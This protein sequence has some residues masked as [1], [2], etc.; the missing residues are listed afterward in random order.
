MIADIRYRATSHILFPLLVCI[1]YWI[2][3]WTILSLTLKHPVRTM[4]GSPLQRR[5]ILI[6]LVRMDVISQEALAGKSFKKHM[7]TK[8][9]AQCRPVTTSWYLAYLRVILGVLLHDML[10]DIRPYPRQ[11][12]LLA[13]NHKAVKRDVF[14]KKAARQR[15]GEKLLG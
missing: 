14:L 10:F 12:L 8:L 2:V 11:D 13:K 4:F 9:A 5:R 3:R 15:N 7:I 1:R 6:I